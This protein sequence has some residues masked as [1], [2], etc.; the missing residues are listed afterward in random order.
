MAADPLCEH[1][2]EF[3][4]LQRQAGAAD[5]AASPAANVI[6]GPGSL[7]DRCRLGV[8]AG[9]FN[10]LTD[11]HVALVE[12]ATGDGA[13]GRGPRLDR[14]FYCLSKQT[15]DKERITG[16]SLT[17]RLWLLRRQVATQPASGVLLVN[18]GLYVEQARLIRATF[19]H[20][21]ELWFIV[22]YDK[23]VQILDPRYYADRAA[24][25]T[26]LFRLA[27]FLVAPRADR[28][29]R[30]VERLLE[31]PENRG[32]A[33]AVKCIATPPTLRYVSSSAVRDAVATGRV[34]ALL[35]PHFV[36][37]FIV[38]TG[39]FAAPRAQPSPEQRE[40]IDRYEL[41]G[42]LLEVLAT[43]PDWT[44]D[45]A[46]CHRL[47]TLMVSAAPEGARFRSWLRRG[48]HKVRPY[49]DP[50]ATRAFLQDLMAAEGPPGH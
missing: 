21:A 5:P 38:A 45:A 7:P 3:L 30:D 28:T 43:V 13:T 32:F 4:A 31:A 9:S 41:R 1:L 44:P 27:R 6:A 8:L 19:P 17:D 37:D 25:L 2:A 24:A 48:E 35:V 42:A 11:A 26:E 49:S 20:L 39:A 50:A 36:A 16:L 40:P 29:F 14:V 12:A 15:V 46:P 47:L 10:P 23:I 22:G 33:A 18:R 34:R